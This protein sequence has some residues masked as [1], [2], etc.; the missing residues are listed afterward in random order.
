MQERFFR[1]QFSEKNLQLCQYSA[2]CN[3]GCSYLTDTYKEKDSY[4]FAMSHVKQQIPSAD[5]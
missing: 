3:F 2:F 4:T 1:A 5:S